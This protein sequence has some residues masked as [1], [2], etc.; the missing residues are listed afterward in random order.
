MEEEPRA[1]NFPGFIPPPDIDNADE[2]DS[3]REQADEIEGD[4]GPAA[5]ENHEPDELIII[6]PLLDPQPVQGRGRPLGSR[7]RHARSRGRQPASSTRR[8]PSNFER[9]I[10]TSS[11]RSR[12]APARVA[13]GSGA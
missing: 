2:E 4:E 5:I 12:T 8:E 10:G 6:A 9:I 7:G 3:E 1:E 11:L 13:R